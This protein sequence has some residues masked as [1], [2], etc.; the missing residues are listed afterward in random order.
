MAEIEYFFEDISPISLPTENLSAWLTH[1]ATTENQEISTLNF[2]LCSDEHLYQ[3]N[4]EYLQHDYYTDVITFDNSEGDSI[5]G[6]IFISLERVTENSQEQG[7]TQLNELRR[8]M[9][10]GLLH[11]VGYND[12]T[13]EEKDLMTEKENAYLSLPQFQF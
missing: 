12:K 3:I 1:V 5:E 8:I 7:T 11:L 13:K 9:V 2:I 10:H 4:L 6:D